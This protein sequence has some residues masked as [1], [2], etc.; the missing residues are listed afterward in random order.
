M[1]LTI[2][3]LSNSVATALEESGGDEVK[4]SVKFVQMFDHFFDCMNVNDFKSGKY[5]QNSF[6]DPYRSSKDFKLKVYIERLMLPKY[7]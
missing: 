2:Q 4:E 6:K 5:S 3:V 1:L 7:E